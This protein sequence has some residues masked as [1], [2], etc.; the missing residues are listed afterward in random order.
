MRIKIV[1]ISYHP[2]RIGI[3]PVADDLSRGLLERGHEVTVIAGLPHYPDWVVPNEYRRHPFRRE[4]RY[5][6]VAV[7]RSYLYA[8]KRPTVFARS[9]FY[10]SFSAS[11]SFNLMRSGPADVVLLISPP[12][13]LNLAAAMFRRVHGAAVVLNVQDIVPDAPIAFGMMTNPLQIRLLRWLETYAYSSSDRIVVVADNFVSNLRAKGVPAERIA[14]VRNWIDTDEIRPLERMN[15]FRR[16]NGI[17]EESFIVM[18]AGNIGLS[19]G[20]EVVLDAADRLRSSADT[21]FVL[22]GGGASLED[23]KAK[24]AAM[25]LPNV[26][27][28]PTQPEMKWVQAAADV[29]LVMQRHNIVDVNL[30]SKIPAIMASGRAMIAGLNP[31]GDAAAIVG[32]A[33]CAVIIEP[34]NGPQLANAICRLRDSEQLRRRLAANGRRYAAAHFARAPAIDAYE[35]ILTDALR[36]RHANQRRR[37]RPPQ[38]VTGMMRDFWDRRAADLSG[39][40]DW[41][42]QRYAHALTKSVNMFD[43]K[44]LELGCGVGSVAA[45][46]HLHGADVTGVDFSGEMIR[47][48]RTLHG[49]SKGLR[50]VESDICTLALD[51]QF[52]V[53]CG[54]AVLHEIDRVQYKQLLAVLDRHLAPGGHAYFLENSYFNVLFRLFRSH[55]VGRYGIPKYGSAS[56]TPFDRAR[57]RLIQ[58]H[59]EYSARTGEIFYL[60][61]RIDSYVLKSRWPRATRLCSSLD[62]TISEFPGA[63]RLKAAL[64]YYQTVYFSHT[65]P[66]P[67][68]I[69][70]PA[71]C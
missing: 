28:V 18:Y 14:V 19:Q 67:R 13:T 6:G 10:G 27:F 45:E 24:S 7:W 51:Q 16:A 65:R 41:A 63:H 59:F 17:A 34:G 26:R 37:G 47:R 39:E 3:A 25:R 46:L 66:S 33:G 31:S 11:A 71:S 40:L 69:S 44:I 50:F 2:D 23:L 36:R 61:S 5:G 58:E 9:A 53:I 4:R 48:A 55:F 70:E 43:T 8:S 56:E 62:Q 49:R 20:L 15:S 1:T 60:L 64:S 21:V 32:E 42:V 68:R 35:S 52:D 22:V 12:P 57:W 54:V 30:P 29:S 38:A